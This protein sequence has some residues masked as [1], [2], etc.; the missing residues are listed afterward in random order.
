MLKNIP[1]IIQFAKAC[2]SKLIQAVRHK[3][4]YFEFAYNQ[5]QLHEF[6]ALALLTVQQ[7]YD[8]CT[9][10]RIPFHKIEK[11]LQN[12]NYATFVIL[13][14]SKKGRR[15]HAPNKNLKLLQ[16]RL[17]LYLQAWYSCI[18]P[19]VCNGFVINN[20][21][22]KYNSNIYSNALPHRGKK[23]LLN[24]DLKD[25]FNTI[26]AMQI[27]ALFTSELFHMPEPIAHAL[28][29]LTT[30]KGILPTGAP[31]SPVLSNFICYKLDLAL[32]KFC[33]EHHITYTRY[34]DDFAFSSNFYFSDAQICQIKKIIQEHGF[35][36]NPEKTRLRSAAKKMKVTGLVVNSKVNVDRK[37]I[38][39]IRAVLHDAE[40]NG[41][42][43]A[44]A[45]YFKMANADEIT[46]TKFISGING[47]VA[48]VGQIKGFDN[49]I[50]KKFKSKLEW[51]ILKNSTG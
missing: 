47:C 9:L 46:Q 1:K 51:V 43:K 41:L 13:K 17:N 16:Q 15:I 24:F 35:N 20:K 38:R 33:H 8:L 50:Y 10:L 42:A 27:N 23:H 30:F 32:W 48:F 36:I 26:N 28:T 40:M 6:R 19:K 25:F 12:P 31:T 21:K 5:L 2:H 4:Y 34:A 14:K 44:A 7:H 39:K 11:I 45:T 3:R 18:R 22:G 29:T 37:H 49:A